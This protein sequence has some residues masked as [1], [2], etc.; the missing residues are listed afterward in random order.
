M[1]WIGF[2][3]KHFTL[4]NVSK[5]FQQ[6]TGTGQWYWEQSF[7]FVQNLG[8]NRNEAFNRARQ[9]SGQTTINID[10]SLKGK[11]MSFI[12]KTEAVCK[13][14]N[15]LSPFFEF[16]KYFDEKITENDDH[17]YLKWYHEQTGNVHAE[18]VLIDSKKFVL[19]KDD[20]VSRDEIDNRMHTDKIF[21]VANTSDELEVTA[22]R[23]INIYGV[24]FVDLEGVILEF[25]IGTKVET[26][27]FTYKEF[28][29]KL[30][31]IDGKAKRIKNKKIK[32]KY[33]TINHTRIIDSIEL[34]QAQQKL[35]LS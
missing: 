24:L 4:W 30:P 10:Y 16:G 13:M 32:I 11:S 21:D 20:L 35:N 1:F 22:I 14:P 26:K 5:P 31:V 15:N 3:N 28:E 2:S 18:K 9:L 17:K 25:E 8:Y 34:V 29:Y 27:Y 23:N 7:Q 6:F 19:Y 33:H 12:K